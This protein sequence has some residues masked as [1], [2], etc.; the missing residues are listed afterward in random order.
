MAETDWLD[1]HGRYDDP[2]TGLSERLTVVQG[3][4]REALDRQPAGEVAIVSACAGQ[5]R[6]LPTGHSP[7]IRGAS[8]FVPD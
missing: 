7:T 6:D 1:W 4:I 5:G 2:H 3:F 8:E